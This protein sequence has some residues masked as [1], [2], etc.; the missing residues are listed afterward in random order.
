MVLAAR[1]VS[2]RLARPALGAFSRQ[3]A[4]PL[5]R[6][7]RSATPFGVRTLTATSRQQGKVLLVLYDVSTVQCHA[8][9][10]SKC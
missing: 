6:A 4:T 1:A 7:T 10:I 8:S 2:S 5:L 3:N 9:T